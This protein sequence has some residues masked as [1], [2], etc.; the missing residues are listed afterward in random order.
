MRDDSE[1]F[2][3]WNAGKNEKQEPLLYEVVNGVKLF[4][5]VRDERA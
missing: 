3:R 2:S 5:V 1:L 4:S